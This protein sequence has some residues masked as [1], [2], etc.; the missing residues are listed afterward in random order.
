MKYTTGKHGDTAIEANKIIVYIGENR[1][2]LT[3]SIDGKL[4]VNKMSDGLNDNINIHPRYAN[5]IE[6]S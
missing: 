3:E 2:R 5:E 6:V 4:T 1:Y